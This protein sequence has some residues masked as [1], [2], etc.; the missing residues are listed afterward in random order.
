MKQNQLFKQNDTVSGLKIKHH[1]YPEQDLLKNRRGLLI[2]RACQNPVTHKS[3][4][5]AV[6]GQANH[7]FTNPSGTIFNIS[8]YNA[9]FGALAFPVEST[10]FT[11]FAGFSWSICICA[12]C[13]THIGWRFSNKKT[14]FFGLISNALIEKEDQHP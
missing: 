2:C 1:L 6:N 13:K 5:I 3:N 4:E 8:C 11:W 9:A 14:T 10:E 12:T 7:V